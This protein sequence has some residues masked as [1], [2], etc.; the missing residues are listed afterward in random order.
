[1][2]ELS[3]ELR[4]FAA[5][6][7]AGP[8]FLVL[9]D[10]GLA[11]LGSVARGYH[12]SGVYTSATSPAVAEAFVSDSRASTSLGAM[13]RS[14]SRSQSDLEVRFLFGGTHLPES[15]RPPTSEVAEATARLRSNQ[16]LTRLV[17]ETVTPRGSV[18]IEGWAPGGRLAGND[19]VPMLGLLGPGQAH[20]F[21]AEDLA[22]DPLV[23]SFAKSGQLVLHAERLE[24]ALAAIVEAGAATGVTEATRSQHVIS[25]GDG[26][27]DI[28]IHTWNQIRRSARPIDLEILTPPLLSSEAARYQEFRSFI[29][30]TEGVPRW[31]GSRLE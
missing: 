6:L 20:L 3:P 4:R 17:T 10:G 1:M 24:E 9:G 27:V 21:S 22:A 25:L 30:A 11:L 7:A 2:A 23:S 19:L 5:Q 28:D 12:W 8:A 18:V 16:E 29:G 13:D 14:P 15:S 26:F 31:R